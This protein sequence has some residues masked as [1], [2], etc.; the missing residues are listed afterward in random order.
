MQAQRFELKYLITED[1]A[2]LVRDF[3]QSAGLELDEYSA[4]RPNLS[5]PVHSLYLDSDT[6]MTYWET[7]NGNKNRFKLRLRYYSTDASSP[8][9]F[10]IKRRMNSC[11]M[12][13]RGGVKQSAVRAL[14]DGQFPADDHLVAPSAKALVALQRFCE[15][16]HKIQAR[17]RVHIFY[18][19]EAYV[20]ASDTVRVTLDRSVQ[21]EPNLDSSIKTEFHNPRGS[22]Q[23]DVI[24]ELKFTDR[25]PNWFK[26]LVRVCNI[27]Q[28]GAAKYVSSIE[29]I[30][31][32]RL[33]N[34][35]T[36]IL[37]G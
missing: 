37:P 32:P 27:M 36:N 23:R 34:A 5:Y 4:T 19:R 26:E 16:L 12:K 18:L 14:L 9:F 17:P 33:L 7:I 21:A 6:L 24:L 29:A 2:K 13:Q 25:F 20:S 8:V 11:I 31:N 15:L 1:K 22:Y 10:E 28:C 30:G 3:V 35:H